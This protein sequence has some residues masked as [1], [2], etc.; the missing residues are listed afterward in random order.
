[1]IK[2]FT[3]GFPKVIAAVQEVIEHNVSIL[4]FESKDLV[5]PHF[6]FQFCVAKTF[7]IINIRLEFSIFVL[8][9][10]VIAVYALNH[11]FQLMPWRLIFVKTTQIHVCKTYLWLCVY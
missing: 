5:L 1:M 3:K 9:G 2:T 10:R 11:T 8:Y 4:W 7:V 6:L